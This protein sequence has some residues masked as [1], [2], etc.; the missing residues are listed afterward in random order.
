MSAGGTA[1]P[2][3][4]ARPAR[5]EDAVAEYVRRLVDASPPVVRR[6]TGAS[7]G[8]SAPFR[9]DTV[10]CVR[11]AKRCYR[12]LGVYD[13]THQGDNFAYSLG[14]LTA[15][16]PYEIHI[17]ARP[18]LGE[19]AGVDWHLNVKDCAGFVDQ[20]ARRRLAGELQPGLEFDE[21]VDDGQTRMHFT[22]GEPVPSEDVTAFMVPDH[23]V[24]LPM[25]WSLHRKQAG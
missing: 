21:L 12:I 14:G 13:A 10:R 5:S 24:V 25:R 6:P 3:R 18:T 22:V 15:R 7:R 2:A 17:A 19:D 11:R 20:F 16:A 23:A 4:R 1:A 9:S 8:P